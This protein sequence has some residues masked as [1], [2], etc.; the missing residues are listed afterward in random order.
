MEKAAPS[1]TAP[2][3]ATAPTSLNYSE[4]KQEDQYIENPAGDSVLRR[5]TRVFTPEEEAKLYRKIDLRIMPIL[6]LLY[7][8]SFM[9]RGNV[10]NARLNGLEADLNMTGSNYNIALSAY[11]ISYCLCEVPANLMLKKLRPSIWLASI[12]VLWGIVMTCMGTVNTYG[13]LVACRIL[14]GVTESG[15]FPGVVLYLT[16]WY[17]RHLC[18]FRIGLFFG[19]AT[20]AG[21]FSG[22]LAYGIGFMSGVGGYNG[23]RWI[24]ILEGLATVVAGF[25]AFWAI[26]DFPST[27]TFLTEDERAWVVWRKRSDG[28]SVGE[29]EGISWPYIIQALTSWQV[30]LGTAYYISIVTPLYGV[31][32][33]L[34][35][36]INS[37]GKYTRPQVQ[38][39][40]VPVYAVACIWVLVSGKLSDMKQH[41]FFF[42]FFDLWL[43]LIG[44]V[45]N[46]SPAPSG[47]KYL[48]LFLAACGSY[49]GLPA[50]VTWLGNNLSG[51]TKRGVGMAFQIGIGNFG[52]IIAS[53][54]YRT[55]DSPHYYI[56]HGVEIGCVCLG[57]VT[58]PLYAY[59][60]KRENKKKE[61][62]IQ[63]Q[64]SLPEHERRVYTVQ[65][66]HDLG[67]KTVQLGSLL[68]PAPGFG[69]MGLSTYYG[70]R[71]DEEISKATL[72]KAIDLG[73]TVWNTSD[74]YANGINESLLGSVLKEGDNRSKV[75]L[76][77]KFGNRV[78]RSC[79]GSKE[80]AATAID[81][82]IERLGSA[83]DAWVCHRMDFTVPIEETVQAMED[84]RQAGKCSYIGLSECSANTLRKANA[85]A[86][87]DFIEIEYSPWTLDH[88]ENGVL[89]AAKELGVVVLAYSPLGRG[90]L[91][92][93]FSSPD[94]L[95]AGDVRHFL[96]RFQ[97]GNIEKNLKLVNELQ[98]IANA[99]GCTSGQLALAWLMAQ[100]DNILPIPG[101]KSQK[102]LQENWE[103]AEVELSEAEVK[104][105]RA[106]VEANRP[107]G[108]RYHQAQMDAMDNR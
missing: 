73:C 25:V 34:P 41:R 84:A 42:V 33:F 83:P 36:I 19:A 82:S 80:W 67:D 9:D 21:A 68:L 70:D 13:G 50:V 56:G 77:T 86:K 31:G 81:L 99:K 37:F 97:K 3:T 10:G 28:S 44:F 98:A 48:G 54:I 15:L 24:F 1:T 57:L 59:L 61:Q 92:G 90:L 14:L 55:Q 88:E 23:W 75:F 53:N 95:V 76:I 103:S 69:A 63:F 105:I 58:A 102:Y 100:G 94:D 30:W 17:P 91:A 45:I 2:P 62:E 51:Q 74:A 104:A 85:V 47:V 40:T 79:D 93:R 20:L 46:I 43:C 7:L 29:A 39:L 22:L 52:G 11:F 60:L 64:A 4:F 16:F 38:L 72:R 6:S 35:T 32:L 108:D 71:P 8:L 96:P 89:A 5:P 107:T 49:G 18:Q 65:E 78:G 101:T 87:I 27:A 66:L 106:V 12:T 26:S